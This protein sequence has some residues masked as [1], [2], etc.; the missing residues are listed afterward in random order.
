MVGRCYR[1]GN[2]G[3]HSG[4]GVRRHRRYVQRDLE[5]LVK[6]P[7]SPERFTIGNVRL[8]GL[9]P[10]AIGLIINFVVLPYSWTTLARACLSAALAL[11]SSVAMFYL[12]RGFGYLPATQQSASQS[13]DGQ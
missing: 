12:L 1:W 6:N 3:S 9:I 5:V 13:R 8:L 11:I 4:L 2:G 7:R 10:V